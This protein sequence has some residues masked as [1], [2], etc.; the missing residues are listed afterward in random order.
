MSSWD[1]SAS[2][3]NSADRRERARSALSTLSAVGAAVA[4]AGAGAL[5]WKSLLPFAW[6]VLGIGLF[7]HLIGM[8]GVRQLLASAG[9]SPPL[10][11]RL[12]YWLCWVIIAV[13]A[14]IW[15][16]SLVR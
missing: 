9:Y 8:V 4:G 3:A 15:M 11:Q 16:W 13:I 7:S 12:A 1:S 6:A 14:I 10:W 2:A 5:L